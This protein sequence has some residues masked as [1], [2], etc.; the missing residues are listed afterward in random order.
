MA[1]NIGLNGTTQAYYGSIC[2]LIAGI[3]D[4]LDGMVA[5]WLGVTSAIGKDL[6]SLSGYCIFWCSAFDDINENA[7]GI[8]YA[9]TQCHG[10]FHVKHVSCIFTGLLWCFTF[11][12]F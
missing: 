4:L 1:N 6:D 3:F 9:T 8:L 11:S 5:R 10:S 7:M 2:I 12:T